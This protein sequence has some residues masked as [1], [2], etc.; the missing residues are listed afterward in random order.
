MRRV[1]V[2]IYRA[3][4]RVGLGAVSD[5]VT[6]T[7][8]DDESF[9][10][11]TSESDAF[12]DEHLLRICFVFVPT[13]HP[14]VHRILRFLTNGSSNFVNHPYISLT[15]FIYSFFIVDF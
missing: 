11:S 6:D 7:R 8:D 13:L 9:R 5:S 4:A 3:G 12:Y 10:F 1:V 15:Y 14:D 2:L